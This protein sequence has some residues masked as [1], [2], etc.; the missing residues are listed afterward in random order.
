[1]LFVDCGPLSVTGWFGLWHNSIVDVLVGL[2]FH[3][4]RIVLIRCAKWRSLQNLSYTFDGTV[5]AF[6]HGVSGRRQGIKRRDVFESGGKR[7][8]SQCWCEQIDV[9][10]VHS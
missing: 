4:G 1:M 7:A 9:V 2:H 6:V 8:I 10:I 3:R 5:V